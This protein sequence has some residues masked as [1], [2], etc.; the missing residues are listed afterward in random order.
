[1]INKECG[2][3][4]EIEYIIRRYDVNGRETVFIILLESRVLGEGIQ[5]R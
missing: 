1:M 5:Y 2:G 3:G 4:N